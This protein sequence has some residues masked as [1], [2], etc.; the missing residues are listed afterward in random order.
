MAQGQ[1]NTCCAS[2]KEDQKTWIMV[3]SFPVNAE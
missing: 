1:F 3:P 2:E